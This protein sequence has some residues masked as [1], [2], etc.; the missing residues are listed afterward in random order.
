MRS[1]T[2]GDLGEVSFTA[3]RLWTCKF[4]LDKVWEAQLKLSRQID[5]IKGQ[6]NEHFYFC[7]SY[8]TLFTYVIESKTIFYILLFMRKGDEEGKINK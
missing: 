3:G 5:W 1:N 6:E 8:S 2:V 4:S 7:D